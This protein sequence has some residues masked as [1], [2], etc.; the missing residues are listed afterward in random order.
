MMIK[1]GFGENQSHFSSN[2]YQFGH[3]AF[4]RDY[5]APGRAHLLEGAKVIT[6]KSFIYPIGGNVS[7]TARV[8]IVRWNLKE[9]ACKTLTAGE[10]DEIRGVFE[11]KNGLVELF[12]SLTDVDKEATG[13]LYDKLLKD[14]ADTTS[15]YQ[16]WFDAM[17]E[18]YKWENI[19]G[20][21]WEINFDTCE[22]Y[23]SK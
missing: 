23:L 16:G 4:I 19:Q 17:S 14:M 12:K 10:R 8:S 1:S 6:S 5:G 15:K 22:V 18:K 7:R 11:S 2:Y 3:Y 20:Y 9:A 21:N 13:R